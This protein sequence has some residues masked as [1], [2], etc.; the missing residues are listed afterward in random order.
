MPK[1]LAKKLPFRPFSA[2]LDNST[3]EFKWRSISR[4]PSNWRSELELAAKEY[5]KFKKPLYLG[6]SGG[7]DSEV[8]AISFLNAGV[9]FTPLIIQYEID[10]E[11]YN[12]HD[13][14]YAISFCKKHKIKPLIHRVNPEELVKM[15]TSKRLAKYKQ[16]AGIFMYAQIYMINLVEDL[17]GM[18]VGG[19]GEQDWRYTNE[20]ELCL[21]SSY[22][23]GC[24]YIYDNE[25]EHWP[26]F[27]QTTPELVRAYLNIPIVKKAFESPK[28]FAMK[29][30]CGNLK[31]KAYHKIFPELEPRKKYHGYERFMEIPIFKSWIQNKFQPDYR[32]YRIPYKEVIGQLDKK[33]VTKMNPIIVTTPRTGSNLVCEMLWSVSKENFGHKNNLYEYFT[34]TDL[35]KCTFKKVDDCIKIDKFERT[36]QVWF[37]SRRDEMLKRLS[38]LQD[39]HRYTIKLFPTE[40]E[41]EIVETIQDHYDIIF[42]ERRDKVRQLLSFCTMVLTNTSHYKS[43]EKV[44]DQVIYDAKLAKIFFEMLDDY[45]A[46][47][48]KNV[49]PTLFYEDFIEQGGD[50][51]ALIKLL[52]WSV[53]SS[54]KF[55]PRFVPTPY[56]ND[57]IEDMVVNKEEWLRDREKIIT[58]LSKFKNT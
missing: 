56:I 8:A 47:K 49:G 54:V 23:T 14:K 18:F 19:G 48:E 12:D 17:G 32:T 20:L 51:A 46:F 13:I 21:R 5:L 26:F 40:L 22:L 2:Q 33:R 15:A 36:K 16:I 55:N 3:F 28:D 41:P 29:E 38:L 58:Q 39:D 9:P 37:E 6:L 43:K 30:H 4:T 35:Y 42:L 57:N 44:V 34:V 53:K 31:I 27:H 24:H 7:I 25:L 52:N 11:V 45:Y 1:N 10:G 50:E